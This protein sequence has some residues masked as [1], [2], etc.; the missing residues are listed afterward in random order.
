MGSYDP[1]ANAYNEKLAALNLE[2]LQH[3]LAGGIHVEPA[4]GQ[5]LGL[6]GLLPV[7]PATYQAAW[8]NRR[9]LDDEEIRRKNVLLKKS[10][11]GDT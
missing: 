6:A 3:Y 4:V 1:M 8:R 10:A 9:A 2:R 7:H 11:S 5:L